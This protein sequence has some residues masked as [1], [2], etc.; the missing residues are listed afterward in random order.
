MGNGA[1]ADAGGANARSID[2]AS[3]NAR[4]NARDEAIAARAAVWFA[5]DANDLVSAPE[6]PNT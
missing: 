2:T 5:R 3:A 1:P 4:A 6:T